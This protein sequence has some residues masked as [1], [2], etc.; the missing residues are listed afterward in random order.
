MPDSVCRPSGC[1][2]RVGARLRAQPHRAPLHTS[3][4]PQ[5]NGKAEAHVAR[6][7]GSRSS[8]ARMQELRPGLWHWEAPAPGLAARRAVGPRR[9]VL[10]LEDGKHLLLFD[11]GSAERDRGA[12][13]GRQPAVVLTAPWHERDTERPVELL[14]APLFAQTTSCSAAAASGSPT[15][16]ERGSRAKRSSTRC[17]RC[18]S[19]RA[20]SSL[21]HTAGLPIALRSS[22]RSHE[23]AGQAAPGTVGEMW[24]TR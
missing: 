23:L 9:L 17:V 1:A 18:W 16:S 12:C 11:P 8:I 2:T 24:S 14:G 3:L 20:R 5:T 19:C 13:E 10:R 4:R 7:R 22:A 6:R 21:R 15:G